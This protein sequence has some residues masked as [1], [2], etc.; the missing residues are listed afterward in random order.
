MLVRW[1]G[2]WTCFYLHLLFVL[3][4]G[5]SLRSQIEGI[6]ECLIVQQFDTLHWHIYLSPGL[7]AVCS[8]NCS[9]LSRYRWVSPIVASTQRRVPSL[10]CLGNR[11]YIDIYRRTE[12]VSSGHAAEFL[13]QWEQHLHLIGTQRQREMG[14]LVCHLRWKFG[15]INTVQD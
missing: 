10:S 15:T 3:L 9:R 11:Y 12:D 2:E 13:Q 8:Q 5:N 1:R 7:A 14:N 4:P 6:K